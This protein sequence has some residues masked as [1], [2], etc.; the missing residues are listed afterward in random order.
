MEEFTGQDEETLGFDQGF[1]SVFGFVVRVFGVVKIALPC[2]VLDGVDVVGQIFG[3]I[4]VKKHAQDVL[5][6]IPT[7]HRTAQVVGDVPNGSVKFG[8]LLVI[9]FGFGHGFVVSLER[10]R[11]IITHRVYQPVV[12]VDGGLGGTMQS[13]DIRFV[14]PPIT[15]YG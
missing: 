15:P 4:A 5:L 10:D 3:D 9:V 2:R 8:T 11:M 14:V 6:E 12:P 1:T 7:V 13:R